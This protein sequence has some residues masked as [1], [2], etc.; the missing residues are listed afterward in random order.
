MCRGTS[1]STEQMARRTGFHRHLFRIFQTDVFPL[2]KVDGRLSMGA[3]SA[4]TSLD[5]WNAA[6]QEG[7]EKNKELLNVN[8][9]AYLWSTDKP[10]PL[11]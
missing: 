1:L 8:L 10:L 3:V 11:L 6:A 5:S 4:G 2:R 7:A 9:N